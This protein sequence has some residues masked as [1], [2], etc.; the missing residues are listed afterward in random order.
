MWCSCP[1]PRE[2][3]PYIP[4]KSHHELAFWSE[5]PFCHKVV[6]QLFLGDSGPFLDN[7][8]VAT[9]DF[10]CRGR[11]IQPFN[12]ATFPSNSVQK[13]RQPFQPAKHKENFQVLFLNF[14]WLTVKGLR[15]NQS[16]DRVEEMK[17]SS[18]FC[19]LNSWFSKMHEHSYTGNCFKNNSLHTEDVTTNAPLLIHDLSLWHST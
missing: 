9:H 18:L 12:S 19:A 14:L 13:F 7:G 5:G 16:N 4:T 11:L 6:I 2:L 10:P 8:Q 1:T 3:F 17:D 15:I